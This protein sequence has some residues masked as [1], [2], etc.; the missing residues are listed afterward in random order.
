L[1]VMISLV[2]TPVALFFLYRVAEKR[3]DPCA[4]RTAT[5]VLAFFL[6]AFFLNAVYTEA[7]YLVLSAGAVWEAL[8][9][10]NL[11]LAGVLGALAATRNPGAI[12]SCR[13]ASSGSATDGSSACVGSR[14]VALVPAGLLGYAVWMRGHESLHGGRERLA[15]GA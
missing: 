11:L 8:V 9:R 13:S 10:R 2:A 6:T 14:G 1:G 4:A 3:Y 7:L 5:L 15:S 12:F